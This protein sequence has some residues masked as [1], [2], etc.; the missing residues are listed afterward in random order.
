MPETSQDAFEALYPTKQA[1]SVEQLRIRSNSIKKQHPPA[2]QI[3]GLIAA[4]S[5]FWPTG[6]PSN[7][8]PRREQKVSVTDFDSCITAPE[9]H[10]Y[11]RESSHR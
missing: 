3:D 11:K 2:L 6:S 4:E 10:G 5:N 7:G 1:L 8:K 9:I